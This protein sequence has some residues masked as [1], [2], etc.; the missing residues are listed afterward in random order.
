MDNTPAKTNNILDLYKSTIESIIER[1]DGFKTN[2][3]KHCV[4]QGIAILE[5]KNDLESQGL[6]ISQNKL[7]EKLKMGTATISRY[8]SIATNDKIVSIVNDK[9]VPSLEQLEKLEQFNQNDLAKLAK[10]KDEDFDKI[11]DE[12]KFPEPEKKNSEK[13]TYQNRYEKLSSQ[14]KTINTQISE[15]DKV[16]KQELLEYIKE[17]TE[18]LDVK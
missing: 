7:A 11:L 2:F 17:L 18:L 14:I 10:L 13:I 15:A 3:L 12:G 5:I 16:T 1:E 9:S 4:D 8:V 6:S